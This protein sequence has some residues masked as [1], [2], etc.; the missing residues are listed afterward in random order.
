MSRT[1]AFPPGELKLRL[2]PARSVMI[3]KLRIK[4]L[5]MAATLGV[6]GC[7]GG[8][9]PQLPPPQIFVAVSAR[10]VSLVSNQAAMVTASLKNDDQPF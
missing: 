3:R 9:L 6:V 10:T 2:V 4:V 7:G 1:Q 5:G 8:S